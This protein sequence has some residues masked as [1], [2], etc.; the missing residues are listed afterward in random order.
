MSLHPTFEILLEKITTDLSLRS[1]LVGEVL[2]RVMIAAPASV[3]RVDIAD[4]TMLAHKTPPLSQATVSKITKELLQVRLITEEP[5]R[6]ERPGRPVV[7]L[8]LDQDTWGIIGIHVEHQQHRAVGLTGVLVNLRGDVLTAESAPLDET[9]AAGTVANLAA[10]AAVLAGKLISKSRGREILGLGIELGGHVHKGHVIEST[11]AGWSQVD[12][13]ALLSEQLKLPVVVE[14]DT[15]AIAV[16]ETYR[17]RYPE[18]DMALVA[19]LDEGIGGALIID[20]RVYRGGHGM[21]AEIGHLTVDYTL[22]PERHRPPPRTGH[23]PGFKDPCPCGRYGHL[24]ALATPSRILGELDHKDLHDAAS[25]PANRG[26]KPTPAGL[27]FAAAGTALGRGLTAL[28][29][30]ANPARIVLLVPAPLAEPEP[31]TAGYEYLQ[32]VEVSVD[33]AFSTGPLDA[34][35][36]EA[37]LTTDRLDQLDQ[38][39]LDQSIEIIGARSA[40]VTVLDAFVDYAR[41]L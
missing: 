28:I 31:G 6:A 17:H 18:R 41:G 26:G 33:Q 32:A 19:V 5:A 11:N 8:G 35:A 12:L 7:P 16:W 9:E 34:R 24:D 25:L 15:N 30:V 37:K 22:T 13:R 38:R 39:A 40:A 27:A 2:S 23:L 20:G 14:N 1:E 21:A 29:D 10:E 3:P 36:H 4:G